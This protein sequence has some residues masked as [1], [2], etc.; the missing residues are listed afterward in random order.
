MRAFKKQERI[1]KRE[2]ETL[3]IYLREINKPK[4]SPIDAETEYQLSQKFLQEGCDR[5]RQKLIN[6]NV[7]FVVSVAKTYQGNGLSLL[8][9]INEGNYGLTKGVNKFDPTKGFKMISYTVWWIR[10]AIM[11][12]ISLDGKVIRIPMNHVNNSARITKATN[13]LE[14]Q[15]GRTPTTKELSD[16]LGLSE[17][18][19]LVHYDFKNI[20]SISEKSTDDNLAIEDMLEGGNESDSIV[21]DDSNKKIVSN[22]LSTF[23][24]RDRE[25]IE[26]AYGIGYEY[27][28]DNEI[29]AQQYGLTVE[30]VRQLKKKL[31]DK[32]LQKYVTSLN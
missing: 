2:T 16:E 29:I 14:H 15:L 20:S 4:Y 11:K 19:I 13:E 10:Q 31:K 26:L 1:T 6:A 28:M 18:D 7:R 22:I 23:K 27:P 25:V 3:T 12:A 9:L 24:K 5:S 32:K 17:Y 8:D 30:R 21:L